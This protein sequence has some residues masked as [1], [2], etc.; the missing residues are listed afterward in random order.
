MASVGPC[1]L[2]PR[3]GV[4]S[5]RNGVFRLVMGV[6]GLG[7][8]HSR[9]RTAFCRPADPHATH[10][11]V[12]GPVFGR[13]QALF[14]HA[15]VIL[16][17]ARPV[18][19]PEPFKK[20][21]IWEICRQRA[22]KMLWTVQGGRLQ[23]RERPE[24]WLQRGRRGVCSSVWIRGGNSFSAVTRASGLLRNGRLRRL[25]RRMRAPSHS[26]CFRCSSFRSSRLRRLR[27]GRLW[28]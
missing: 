19:A 17:P 9:H 24:R 8:W 10:S 18:G 16:G 7:R 5:S 3:D 13:R 14:R 6:L 20:I 21:T 28:P 4:L 25:G 27:I 26:R 12:S 1:V 22:L 2:R 11:R 23:S 15:M